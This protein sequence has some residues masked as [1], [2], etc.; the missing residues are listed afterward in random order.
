[1]NQVNKI[2]FRK[3]FFNVPIAT[4]RE[5][6]EKLGIKNVTWTMTAAAREYKETQALEQQMRDN[7]DLRDT[8]LSR[9]RK[10]YTPAV[11]AAD[12]EA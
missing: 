5:E 4:I 1:M 6:V 3:E 11:T 7:P 2:N 9:E 8:W 12:D 10:D